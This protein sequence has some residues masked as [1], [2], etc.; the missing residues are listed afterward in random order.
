MAPRTNQ[1]EV[2]QPIEE[3][4]TTELTEEESALADERDAMEGHEFVVG[5]PE[6]PPSEEPPVPTEAP[7]THDRQVVIAKRDTVKATLL[8]FADQQLRVARAKIGADQELTADRARK[9]LRNI[10]R[11]QAALETVKNLG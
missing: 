3:P 6:P 7:P 1:V 4:P 8:R 5:S 9:A 2:E 11:A 10:R